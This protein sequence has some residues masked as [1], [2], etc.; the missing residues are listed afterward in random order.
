[1]GPL[2]IVAIVLLV[3]CLAGVAGVARRQPAS[4]PAD[5]AQVAGLRG[6]FPKVAPWRL[7]SALV[8][9]GH[10]AATAAARMRETEEWR[11]THVDFKPRDCK[12]AAVAVVERA[13]VLRDIVAPEVVDAQFNAELGMRVEGRFVVLDL[14]AWRA[15]GADAV[16]PSAVSRAALCA[17]ERAVRADRGVALVIR[18]CWEML[19]AAKEVLEEVVDTSKRHYGGTLVSVWALPC[20]WAVRGLLRVAS[21]YVPSHAHVFVLSPEDVGALRVDGVPLTPPQQ[22]MVSAVLGLPAPPQV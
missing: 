15:A 20:S 3:L 12:P 1:M 18:P 6:E 10:D 22:R 8:D 21:S 2:T 13:G 9:A 11:A 7:A 19:D 17:V 5:E 16:P 14:V 4:T